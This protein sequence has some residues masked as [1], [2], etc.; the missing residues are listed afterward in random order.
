MATEDSKRK[1]T[2]ILA[3]AKKERIKG[4]YYIYEQYKSQLQQVCE[5]SIQY[6]RAIVELANALKV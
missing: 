6:E 1:V 5:D 2:A 3:E 4:R